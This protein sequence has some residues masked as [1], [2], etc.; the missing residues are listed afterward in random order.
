MSLS[1]VLLS[2]DRPS[3]LAQALESVMLQSKQPDEII[4]VDNRST[5]S[6]VIGELVRRHPQVRLIANST[7]QGFAA[8]MNQ[9]VAA[10]QGDF[11]Y[12]TEDDIVLDRDCM[13]QLMMFAAQS[14]SFGMASALQLNHGQHTIRCAGGDVTLGGVY[15]Q[16]I[17]GWDEPE[18]R[19]PTAPLEVGYLTGSSIFARR[20][21]LA[22]LGGFREDFF[23]YKEDVELCIRAR[24]KGLKL[25][26]VPSARSFHL[27]EASAGN[28]RRNAEVEFHKLKNFL[29]LYLLHAK[30]SVLPRFFAGYAMEA[31]RDCAAAQ[32]S[33]ARSRL[34]ATAWCASNFRRLWH[35][36]RSFVPDFL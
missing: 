36:R 32:W 11:V 21:V 23:L 26:V 17:F 12:L 33:R 29:A 6:N 16:S 9:G 20:E 19:V 10:A 14:P 8:A 28:G 2:F 5:S 35:D 1:I 24:R 27:P 31:L 30:A 25:F 22:S 7:N 34:H 4:V 18:D 15:R 3:S 13:Q